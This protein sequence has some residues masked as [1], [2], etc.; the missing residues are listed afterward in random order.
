MTVREIDAKR[1]YDC[2]EDRGRHDGVIAPALGYGV[3]FRRTAGA[4][5]FRHGG[6]RIAAACASGG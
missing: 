1:A 3:C 4:S 5:P 6:G 2:V